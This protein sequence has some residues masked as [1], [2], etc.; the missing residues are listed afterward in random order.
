MKYLGDAT[1]IMTPYYD[2]LNKPCGGTFDDIVESIGH[3]PLVELKTLS[4]SEDVRIFAKLESANPTG[5]VKDR[6]ARS[7]MQA[8]EESGAIAPGQTILEPSSGNTG[9]ALAAIAGIKGYPIKIVMPTSVSI[10]RRQML[11]IFGADRGFVLLGTDPGAGLDT[12]VRR[13]IECIG[14]ARALDEPAAWR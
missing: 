2:L 13:G 6:V 3:T 14:A 9:I 4:P 12:A 10:E 7:M 1:P 11:E 5:S 8:A